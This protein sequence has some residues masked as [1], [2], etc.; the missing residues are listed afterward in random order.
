[1]N[2]PLDSFR[3]KKHEASHDITEMVLIDSDRI[4]LCE[5]ANTL[6]AWMITRESHQSAAS[7]PTE[8][9]KTPAELEAYESALRYLGDQ[10]KA[11]YKDAESVKSKTETETKADFELIST[12]QKKE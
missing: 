5:Q 6:V 7:V 10:F 12:K 9:T 3:H 2:L 11:G 1:M 4:K 8:S